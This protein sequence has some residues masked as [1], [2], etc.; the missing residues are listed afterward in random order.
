MFTL[1]HRF[2]RRQVMRGVKRTNTIYGALH[3]QTTR[4]VFVHGSI[5][6]WHALGLTWTI[7]KDSPAIYIR[8]LLLFISAYLA[9]VHCSLFTKSSQCLLC[10]S[11]SMKHEKYSLK[12]ENTVILCQT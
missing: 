12:L 9:V 10:P 7:N 6:P 1:M 2:D 5:D 4:V 11:L 8:G 3:I